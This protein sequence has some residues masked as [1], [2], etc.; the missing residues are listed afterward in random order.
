MKKGQCSSR[1]TIEVT[2]ILTYCWVVHYTDEDPTDEQMWNKETIVQRSW[3]VI[4]LYTNAAT[5][6][7]DDK[8][9]AGRLTLLLRRTPPRTTT[10]HHHHRLPLPQPAP[11]VVS[12]SQPYQTA[13][14]FHV[15]ILQSTRHSHI[16]VQTLSTPQEQYTVPPIRRQLPVS[17]SFSQPKYSH[18]RY[19]NPA[20]SH[21]S[22]PTKLIDLWPTNQHHHL[23]DC[24]YRRHRML[25]PCASKRSRLSTRRAGTS[26][27]A[28]G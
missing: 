9:D 3:D 11:C 17:A 22:S 25:L 1:W 21:P 14:V 20:P 27:R 16:V 28:T 4:S 8:L 18:R 26:T 23:H 7:I 12:T 5:G 2:G 24:R 15:D 13:N 6:T 10:T 19:Y